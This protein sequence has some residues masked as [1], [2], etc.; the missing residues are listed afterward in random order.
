MYWDKGKG[1]QT[2]DPTFNALVGISFGYKISK[3]CILLVAYRG[4]IN[5]NP[6]FGLMNNIS[7]GNKFNF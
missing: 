4:N 6:K 7:I 3:R 1:T 5:T 2:T